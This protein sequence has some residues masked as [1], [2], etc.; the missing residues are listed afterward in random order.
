LAGAKAQSQAHIRN[1]Q[2][3]I[4]NRQ[5]SSGLRLASPAATSARLFQ[6][7]QKNQAVIVG[8]KHH[9]PA[10]ATGHD[11]IHR[12]RIL[13]SQRPRHASFS[14][15]S[16]PAPILICRDARTAPRD[17]IRGKLLI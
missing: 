11:M 6:P 7:L 16:A 15:I 9:L 8:F 17:V 3:K 13:E 10:I 12:S 14:S 5:S 4:I 2:S 1:Q